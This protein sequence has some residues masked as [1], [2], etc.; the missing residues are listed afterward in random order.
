MKFKKGRLSADVTKA[1]EESYVDDELFIE[2]LSK[3]SEFYMLECEITKNTLGY[4]IPIG[5]EITQ[6]MLDKDYTKKEA[7]M[8]LMCTPNAWAIEEKYLEVL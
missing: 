6:E 7:Y 4:I 8:L 1:C 2:Q 5:L 3:L